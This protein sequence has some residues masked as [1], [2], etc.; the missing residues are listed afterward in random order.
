MIKDKKVEA[1]E[2]SSVRLTVTVDKDSVR[3][4]YDTL[5]TDYAKSVQLKG[6]RK[7]HV[8]VVVLERKF[9]E[10]LKIEAAEKVLESSLKEVFDEIEERP[11]PYSTPRMENELDLEFDKDFTFVV[12]YDVYPKITIGAYK[13]L[14]IE[15]P[16]VIIGEEDEKR[17][18]EALQ[19]QN[20]VVIDK[21]DSSIAKENV[22]TVNYV[23]LDDKDAEVAS[24]RR[25]DFVFTVG[26]GYNI[27]KI[28]DDVIGM[29]KGDE[30]VF[31]KEFADDYEI[32]SLRGTKKRIRVT[33]TAVKEKQLP[34]IDDDLAQD[35]SDKYKTL[36][37]LK[38][39]IRRR[40]EE[41]AE[42]RI[43]QLKSDA[44]IEKI[45]EASSVDL[46]ESMIQAE[47]ESSWR[48]FVSQL[49][50]QEQ[51]VIAMLESQGR[52]QEQLFQEWRPAAEKSIKAQLLIH[53]MIEDEKIEATDEDAEAEVKRQAESGS[54]DSAE[55]M[56]Y[57][58]KNQMLDMLKHDIQEKKLFDLLFEQNKVKNGDKVKFLDL[59]KRNQ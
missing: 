14:E 34:A 20:S 50:A 32:E 46:P 6:F 42:S 35:I 22:V 18:L 12:S 44:V 15:A 54:M 25:E 49:R 41:S 48:N 1:Q 16:Q 30:K 40:L 53:R 2:K 5:V 59:M 45:S 26:S 24:T 10:S 43:R 28:D 3:K 38:K 23:E 4:E 36:D 58:R 37:D 7:G 56:D 11:L 9:G 55:L 31:E 27:Y 19:E 13:G 57:Y 47:L 17:E 39:D 51:Q 52:S 8:P 21:D 33:V 29:K